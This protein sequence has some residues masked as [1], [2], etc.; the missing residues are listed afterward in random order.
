[1]KNLYTLSYGVVIFLLTLSPLTCPSMHLIVYR[2]KI[3]YF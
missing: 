2:K 1:M 3:K